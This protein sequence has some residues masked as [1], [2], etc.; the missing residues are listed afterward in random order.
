MKRHLSVVVLT[1]LAFVTAMP[2]Q[3]SNCGQRDLMVEKLA[4]EYHE[5][6]AA[7]GLQK[8]RSAEAILEIWA[9]SKTGTFTVLITNPQGVSCIVAAGTDFFKASEKPEA[10]GTES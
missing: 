2:A 8:V 5:H 3:A 4:T 9:S 7:G 1:S 6:L 10:E